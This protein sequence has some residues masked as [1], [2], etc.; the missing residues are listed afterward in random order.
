[1][2]HDYPVMK[3]AA[4]NISESPAQETDK[5][6]RLLNE[7]ARQALEPLRGS[8]A[9]A[10]GK[11]NLIGL[12]SLVH[13]LG[14][15]W[16]ARREQVYDYVERALTRSLGPNGSFIRIS[17]TDYLITQPD[18]GPFAAQA[19]C[20]R[21]LGD[22]LKH[23]VGTVSIAGPGVCRVLDLSGDKI[24]SV[25]VNPREA[26]DGE[27]RERKAL[28]DL[29]AARAQAEADRSLLS[30]ER[31]TPFIASNGRMVRVSCRL[32]PVFE[33][34]G[35]TRIGYRLRRQVI[36]V[37]TDTPLS[38][39]EVS[40]LS[41]SD[42]LHIDMATIARG[43]MRLNASSEADQ[44]LSLIIPV[45]YITLTNHSGRSLLATAFSEARQRVM[46]GVIC[47]VCDIEDVPQAP[48]LAAISLIRPWS[49]FVVGHLRDDIPRATRQMR[50]AGLQAISM[51]CPAYI[52]GDAQFLGW[53]RDA[54]RA[55]HKVS[56]SVMI[57]GCSPTR[58]AMAGLL[59][60]SH[61]SIS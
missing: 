61:A 1:M 45:S 5:V 44:T 24:V 9:V 59:G 15:R 29:A 11:V 2:W 30:P 13:A 18:I 14:K 58:I 46:T 3:P 31:W 16:Q 20:L 42:L 54:I 36:V 19:G 6:V 56:R 52:D 51:T 17:E 7:A 33:L 41:R 40:N 28:T 23:F 25:P 10:T 4:A 38:S 35:A 39:L 57:Y 49:V 60:A 27:W 21:T 50:D 37:E 47:E 43:L 26:N 55:A 32:E 34:K 22:V 12:D 53:A 8:E 48:L